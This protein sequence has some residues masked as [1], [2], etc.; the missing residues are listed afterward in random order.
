MPA[1]SCTTPLDRQRP[2]LQ[3]SFRSHATRR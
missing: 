3:S 2:V 1:Q